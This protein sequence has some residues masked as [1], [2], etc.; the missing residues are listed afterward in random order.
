MEYIKAQEEDRRKI[1]ETK[2][3]EERIHQETQDRIRN[4]QI[5]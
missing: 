3:I 4:D 1:T 5:K 2:E